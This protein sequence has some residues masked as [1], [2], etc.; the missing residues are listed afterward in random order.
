MS[1][2]RRPTLYKPEHAGRARELRARGAT[3]PDLAGRF[4]VARNTAIERERTLWAGQRKRAAE[5]AE[6]AETSNP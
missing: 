2:P 1:G 5:R 4:G 6:R 3:G